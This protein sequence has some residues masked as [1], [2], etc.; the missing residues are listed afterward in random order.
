MSVCLCVYPR[1]AISG[2]DGAA[3]WRQETQATTG[4]WLACHATA[5]RPDPA[6]PRHRRPHATSGSPPSRGETPEEES[7]QQ[8][9]VVVVVREVT[10]ERGDDG[11]TAAVVLRDRF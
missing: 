5:Q 4:R 8:R 7:L 11:V 3:W 2:L 6:Q 10:P 9:S 1:V